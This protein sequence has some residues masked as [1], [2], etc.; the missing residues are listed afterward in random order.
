VSELSKSGQ[1]AD[2]QEISKTIAV[3]HEPDALIELCAIGTQRV[4]SGYYDDQDALAREAI[5]A[6]GMGAKDHARAAIQY[7]SGDIAHHTVY[8]HTGW[9]RIGGAWFYVHCD[10][11]IGYDGLYDSVKVKLPKNLAAFRLPEPP[12]GKRLKNAVLASLRVLDLAPH[13]ST[14]PLFG[15]IWRSVLGPSDFSLHATGPTGTFK[16]SL[17]ALAMQHFGAGFDVRQLPGAWSSTANSNA[18]LQFTL[19]DALFLIDDFVPGGSRADV[20]RLHR[21]ADRIF[22]GQGNNAGRGRLGRD[23]ISLRDANPPRGLTLSTGE[24]IPRGQSLASRVWLLEFSPG[25]V[26]I[27]KLA[28]CQADAAAGVY[29]E[30]MAGFLQW[31]APQY[32]SLKQCL[33]D[34]IKKY[35]GKATCEGQHNRTPEITA[36]LNLGIKYF[37]WFAVHVKALTEAMAKEIRRDAWVALLKCASAQTR[38]QGSE[39]PAQHFMALVASALSSGDAALANAQ[40]GRQPSE[41]R[42]RLVGW[43]ADDFVLLEP[44]AAYAMANRLAEQQGQGLPVRKHT[45][46]KRLR[47]R[48]FLAR[49]GNGHNTVQWTVGGARRRVL[50]LRAADL[51]VPSDAIAEELWAVS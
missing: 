12:A 20:D 29:A 45:M 41:T 23:G 48:G 39:E 4:D 34:L 19:K 1:E 27:H 3:L 32:A 47:E 28:E 31:L 2:I 15:A 38:G 16:T 43:I 10:G 18:A 44:E 42:G 22:R 7:L 36:N 13:S 9:R 5:L 51:H 40:T 50:C 26:N 14:V 11:A 35:R 37:L 21:D 6:A 25:D 24:D 46:W 17:A 49:H 33:P 30:A 8:T